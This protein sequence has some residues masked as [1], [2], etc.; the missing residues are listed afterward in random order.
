LGF[1]LLRGEQA[2]GDLQYGSLLIVQIEQWVQHYQPAVIVRHD[3]DPAGLD[4]QDHIAVARAVLNV[5]HHGQS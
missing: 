5:A 2:D 1:E 3:Y 4:P